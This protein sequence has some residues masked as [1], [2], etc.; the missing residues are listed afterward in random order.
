MA[1]KAMQ[2]DAVS[3]QLIGHW[4][5][6]GEKLV[7]LAA[8]IPESRFEFRPL[9]G[10]RSVGD[11]LR[12]VAFW[13]RYVADKARGK[14][15][16]DGANELPKEKFS[17]KTQVIDELKGSLAEASEAFKEH[18]GGLSPELTD[19]LVSFIEHNSEHYGQVAVYA[20]MN[21]IVPPAS[22]G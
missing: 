19:M 18:E 20:R 16:D 21:G 22:R 1:T 11:V 12:H 10:V 15:A 7:A 6:G 17:T 9:E 5:L 4:E 13:N 14:N 8:E 2:R 3:T